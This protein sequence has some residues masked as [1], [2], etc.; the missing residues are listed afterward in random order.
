MLPLGA[1]QPLDRDLKPR[2]PTW[3]LSEG[4]F[5]EAEGCLLGEVPIKTL[6]GILR[7]DLERIAALTDQVSAYGEIDVTLENQDI[8]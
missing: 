8:C 6:G 7:R 2:D 3:I 5:R 4:S 1:F